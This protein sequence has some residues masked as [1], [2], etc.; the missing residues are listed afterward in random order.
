MATKKR[1]KL[2]DGRRR[3]A[4]LKD[5]QT[6]QKVWIALR[7]VQRRTGCSTKVLNLTLQTLQ[8]FLVAKMD[9][10]FEKKKENTEHKLICEAGCEYDE[11]HGCVGCNKHVFG[12]SDDRVTCPKCGHCRFDEQTRLPN[13]VMG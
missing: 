11:L 1:R 4:C 5:R 9:V 6:M 13:E 10:T 3:E 12:P 7:S 8:P 2:N